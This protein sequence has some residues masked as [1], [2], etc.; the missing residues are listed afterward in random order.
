MIERIYQHKPET[1]CLNRF[2]PVRANSRYAITGEIIRGLAYVG[3]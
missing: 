1:I 2:S 3:L